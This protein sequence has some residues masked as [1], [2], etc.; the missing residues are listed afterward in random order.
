MGISHDDAV[1]LVDNEVSDGEHGVCERRTVDKVDKDELF[2][3]VV[4]VDRD[5][6]YGLQRLFVTRQQVSSVLQLEYCRFA[7]NASLE[8][9]D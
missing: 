2:V 6:I 8:G 1:V 9:F 4:V 7:L 5:V 3:A